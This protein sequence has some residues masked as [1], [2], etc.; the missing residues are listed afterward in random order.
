MLMK[1]VSVIILSYNNQKILSQTINSLI[2]SVSPEV[3]I[4]VVDNGSA[5]GSVKYLKGLRRVKAIFSPKNL[6]FTGGNNLGIKYGLD[7]GADYLLLLNND[8]LIKEDF[9]KPMIEFMEKNEKAGILGP[10]IYFAPGYEFHQDRYSDKEKGRVIWYAGGRIDW[11]NVVA[12]HRGVDEVDQGQYDQVEETEFVTGCCL[13]A[14]REV[15]EEVGL[16]DDRYFLYYEDADFCQRARKKGWSVIY[17][18]RARIWHLNAASSGSGGKL[19]D[20]FITRNRLLF[21]FRWA[22][23]RTKQALFRQSLRILLKGRKWQKIG[24]RDFYLGRFGRG[25]WREG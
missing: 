5:D 11:N 19:H 10:K 21:G 15:F 9:I 1:K 23:W 20:Y 25:G 13:L 24:V 12:S 16:L 3:E 8:V 18:P 7:N 17:F 14:R 6:G 4:V 22:S 2:D